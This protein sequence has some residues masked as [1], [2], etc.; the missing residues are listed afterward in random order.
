MAQSIIIRKSAGNTLMIR[1]SNS[2]TTLGGVS[3]PAT[4][5]TIGG[6][7]VGTGL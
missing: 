3:T 6:V 1:A 2:F 4:T 7:I 5:T